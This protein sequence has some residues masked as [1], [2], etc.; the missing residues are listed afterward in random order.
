MYD[1][2][3]TKKLLEVYSSEELEELRACLEKHCREYPPFL[4]N[5]KKNADDWTPEDRPD[6][7]VAL[8]TYLRKK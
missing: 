2:D 1:P 3:V 8:I 7:P 5:L 4:D 6:K